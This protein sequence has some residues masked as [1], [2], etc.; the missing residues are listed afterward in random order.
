MFCIECVTASKSE[1]WLFASILLRQDCYWSL[2]LLLRGL[3]LG[4]F[5]ERI[6]H[7]HDWHGK[8]PEMTPWRA[9]WMRREVVR[10]RYARSGRPLYVPAEV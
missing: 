1:G 10:Y 7:G 9:L 2:R 4:N 5:E 8:H 3:L 6:M